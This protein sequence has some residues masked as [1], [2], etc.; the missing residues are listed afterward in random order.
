M[1]ANALEHRAAIEAEIPLGKIGGYE[2]IAG[3]AVF[4]A[5]QAGAYVT[6]SVIPVDGGFSLI[7]K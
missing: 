6:A 4:L 5:S 1:I 7:G 2:D 3:V